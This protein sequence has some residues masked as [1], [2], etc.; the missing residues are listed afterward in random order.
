[1]TSS[2]KPDG[3]TLRVSHP[4]SRLQGRVSQKNER[5]G[6]PGD[7]SKEETR[8]RLPDVVLHKGAAEQEMAAGSSQGQRS[9]CTRGTGEGETGPGARCELLHRGIYEITS[10]GLRCSR[11]AKGI[12]PL[13]CGEP[14]A[15]AICYADWKFGLGRDWSF[16]LVF[17]FMYIHCGFRFRVGVR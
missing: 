13:N 9:T 8:L 12:R 16:L 6:N 7:Q 3:N 1:M 2:L 14:L 5:I 11:W 4:S 17:L 15:L 10:S